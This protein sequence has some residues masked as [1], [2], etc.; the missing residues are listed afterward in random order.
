MADRHSPAAWLL[1]GLIQ[2]Y[3]VT[4]SYFLGR[5]CRFLPT[6]SEYGLEAVRRHG[7]RRGGALAV[8]RILRC[9]PWGGSGHDPVPD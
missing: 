2:L 9:H 7:A 8:R 6:C 5:R 1:I 3:R 4:L